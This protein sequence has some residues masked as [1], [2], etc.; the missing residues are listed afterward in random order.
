[1]K[2][3][4]T[5]KAEIRNGESLAVEEAYKATFQDF[6]WLRRTGENGS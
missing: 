1:M 6:L 3:E 4:L 5:A 2:V